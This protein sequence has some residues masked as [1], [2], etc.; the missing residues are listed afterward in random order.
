MEKICQSDANVILN[1]LIKEFAVEEKLQKNRLIWN[2]L[3]YKPVIV[4]FEQV[5]KCN[6]QKGLIFYLERQKEL[7]KVKI[8]DVEMYFE[9]LQPWSEIDAYL[10]DLTYSWLIAFTHEDI[11]LFLEH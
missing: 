3:R 5:T 11:I 1:K 6:E 9:N 4:T 2:S 7:F 8:P 10:F